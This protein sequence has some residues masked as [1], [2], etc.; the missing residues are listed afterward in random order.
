MALI[1]QKTYPILRESVPTSTRLSVRKKSVTLAFKSETVGD[2]MMPVHKMV[3]ASQSSLFKDIFEAKEFLPK[4]VTLK[5]IR[6]RNVDPAAMEVFI[7]QF[8]VY[9]KHRRI[10]P[11]NVSDILKLSETFE[12]EQHS[13]HCINGFK[14][15]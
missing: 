11:N 4:P 14:K 1:E 9:G 13:K 3:L 10:E 7:N 15:H 6:L 8:P 12:V 2:L 5:I